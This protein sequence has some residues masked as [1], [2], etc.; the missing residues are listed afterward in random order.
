M[1]IR[2]IGDPP[3]GPTEDAYSITNLPHGGKITTRLYWQS[4]GRAPFTIGQLAADGYVTAVREN[5]DKVFTRW[6]VEFVKLPDSHSKWEWSAVTIPGE[7]GGVGYE[8]EPYKVRSPMTVEAWVN[9]RYTYHATNLPSIFTKQT[10]LRMPVGGGPV[11]F[12]GTVYSKTTGE[13]L[14]KIAKPAKIIAFS[15]PT[16]RWEPNLWEFATGEVTIT[17]W[18]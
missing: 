14:G 17:D 4:G 11:D 6:E 18:I 8:W 12:Y 2:F 10:A 5:S 16:L 13:L 9:V 15:R 3:G 7:C 1:S